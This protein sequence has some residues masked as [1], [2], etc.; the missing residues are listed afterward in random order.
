MYHS[1]STCPRGRWSCRISWSQ[2]HLHDHAR[3]TVE[4]P[5]STNSQAL[6]PC[7][8]RAD[9]P[10][11]KSVGVADRRVFGGMIRINES[12]SELS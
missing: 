11:D 8:L 10:G 12:M 9:T 7:G 1:L 6:L 3:S 5:S 4:A 2:E